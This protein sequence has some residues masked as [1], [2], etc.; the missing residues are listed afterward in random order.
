MDLNQCNSLFTLLI[1]TNLRI[2]MVDYVLWA[3]LVLSSWTSNIRQLICRW[4]ILHQ[5]LVFT[6]WR[7]KE[8]G[9]DKQKYILI[10]QYRL[11]VLEF[12]ESLSRNNFNGLHGNK[13]TDRRY[14]GHTKD[15]KNNYRVG[16]KSLNAEATASYFFVCQK[17]NVLFMVS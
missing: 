8:R 9:R 11:Y 1:A 3:C 14:R 10:V 17:T 7:H 12:L 16:H 13:G 15:C 5:R 4:Q 2:M 6:E